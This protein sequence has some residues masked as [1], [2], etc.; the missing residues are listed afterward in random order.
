L[1]QLKVFQ[2]GI[3]M[4]KVLRGYSKD[5]DGN[6]VLIGTMAIPHS[7]DKPNPRERKDKRDLIRR[8]ATVFKEELAS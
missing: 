4:T 2:G 5:K 8:G 1:N 6:L 3:S 7:K